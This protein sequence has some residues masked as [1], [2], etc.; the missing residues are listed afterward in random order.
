MM[1]NDSN[2]SN[3]TE[4]AGT[5]PPPKSTLGVFGWMKQNLFCPWYNSVYTALSCLILYFLF[6]PLYRWGIQNASF[7]TEACQGATSGACWGFIR[8][9]WPN[10][11]PARVIGTRA[12]RGCSASRQLRSTYI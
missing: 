3:I 2:P 1:N 12:K 9:M 6:M 5:L 4:E 10:L 7:G 11:T 8:E